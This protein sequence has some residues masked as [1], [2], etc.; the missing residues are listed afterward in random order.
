VKLTGDRNQ[1]PQC[2]EYFNSTAAFEKHR[3]GTFGEPQGDGT[4]MMHTRG[5]LKVSEMVSKGMAKNND[6][7]WVTSVN[8]R[9]SMGSEV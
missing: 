7:W 3:S 8:L 2:R 1:C 6:G 4:Y 9:F 5:C